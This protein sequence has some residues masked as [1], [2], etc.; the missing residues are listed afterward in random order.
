[1]WLFAGK[2]IIKVFNH[3]RKGY[4]Y[5]KNVNCKSWL[6]LRIMLYLKSCIY[7]RDGV[8]LSIMEE[9]SCNFKVLSNIKMY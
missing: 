1:M 8:G 5:F 7:M 6:G 4:K 9:A 3:L 2:N